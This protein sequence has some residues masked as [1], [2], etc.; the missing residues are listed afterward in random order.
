[1]GEININGWLY[2]VDADLYE[3]SDTLF[4]EAYSNSLCLVTRYFFFSTKKR[5]VVRNKDGNDPGYVSRSIQ[6]LFCS[7]RATSVGRWGRV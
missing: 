5:A 7:F 1:M 6:I 4:K 2:L 3:Y